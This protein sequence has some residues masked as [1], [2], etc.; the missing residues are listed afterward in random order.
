MK[1]LAQSDIKVFSVY[2]I[3][4]PIE[5]PCG[6]NKS[7]HQ[8]DKWPQEFMLSRYLE[9]GE[10]ESTCSSLIPTTEV[11]VSQALNPQLLQSNSPVAGRTNCGCS[12]QLPGMNCISMNGAFLKNRTSLSVRLSWIIQFYKNM[13]S[14]LFQTWLIRNFFSAG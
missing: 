13:F 10:S 5:P 8:I 1:L 12:G 4:W 6:K 14:F 9:S 11:P 2:L 3:N 7:L